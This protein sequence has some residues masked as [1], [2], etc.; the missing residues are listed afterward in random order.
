MNSESKERKAD[1]ITLLVASIRFLEWLGPLFF[2]VQNFSF[3]ASG[4]PLGKP[5]KL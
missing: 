4:I 2:D 5:L 3:H 1:L